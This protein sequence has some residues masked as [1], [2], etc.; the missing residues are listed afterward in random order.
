V[1]I[2]HSEK[3][4]YLSELGGILDK[5][6]G[7][8]LKGINS[9]EKQGIISSR[10][11]GNQRLFKINRKN[12]LFEEIKSIVRKT[13]GAK[14]L[15]GRLV[16]EIKDVSIALI[17][18][19][20]A[21]DV[22]RADSDI[23]LLVVAISDKAEDILLDKLGD[24]EKKLQRE[25]NYKIYSKREFAKKRKENDPFIIEILSDKYILL[26]GIL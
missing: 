5:H 4:Y 25:I 3:E 16:N 17:Y 22:L 8:F 6:P 13:G 21:R 12:P 24:I 1:L 20:Y 19:T 11:E 14:E 26:K 2:S 9:L 23:D 7:V 15:L 18:G 10:K